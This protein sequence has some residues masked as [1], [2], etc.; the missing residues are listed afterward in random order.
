MHSVKYGGSRE[1]TNENGQW[2]RVGAPAVISYNSDGSIFSESFF[3]NGKYHR[4]DGAAYILYDVD[5]SISSEQFWANGIYL[6]TYE[7]GFWAL[8]DYLN[9]EKRKSPNILKLLARIP[10]IK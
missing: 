10:D 1:W 2:H 6:G 7:T 8:W 9:E 3:N 5:G 4:E